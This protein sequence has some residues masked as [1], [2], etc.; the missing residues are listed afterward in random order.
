MIKKIDI[1]KFGLFTD[2]SWEDEI[3]N[4]PQKDIF[5]KV[6]IIYGRNYSGKTTLSRVFRC[7]EQKQLHKD[8][9]DSK[10][11]LITDEGVYNESELEFSK[12]IKV[13]NTDFIKDNLSWLHN[14]EGEI[15]PFTLLGGDNTI[16]QSK[17]KD[18]GDKLGVFDE[19]KTLMRTGLCILRKNGKRLRKIIIIRKLS[20]LMM[21]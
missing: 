10:F 18:I 8:Y 2:Y 1:Q 21:I 15:L 12:K 4:D 17:I 19:E 16:I 13:Y 14:E 9:T 7:I 11:S 6:N 5:R 3:G 20:H